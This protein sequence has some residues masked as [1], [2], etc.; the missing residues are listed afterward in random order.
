MAR[1]ICR[2]TAVLA[3]ALLGAAPLS[4]NAGV[5]AAA[6]SLT[7]NVLLFIPVVLIEVWRIRRTVPV[8]R[9]RA[10]AASAVANLASV[11]AGVLFVVLTPS[12][13]WTE[14][15]F[16]L[17]TLVAFIPLALITLAIEVP[18]YQLWF[19]DHPRIEV[20]RAVLQAHGWSYGLLVLWVLVF[21]TCGTL[22]GIPRPGRP[23]RITRSSC[24][25]PAPPGV[26]A[27]NPLRNRLLL[28]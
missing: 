20:R 5:P 28:A 3:L 13:L 1:P 23:R 27:G 15:M 2:M 14:D 18:I 8:A 6:G 9:P 25:S 26:V 21:V 17:L 22:L 7:L 11:L 16:G 12:F 10:L 19:K 24:L 4:A